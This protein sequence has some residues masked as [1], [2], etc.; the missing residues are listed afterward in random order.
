MAF[1]A[2]FVDNS[3]IGP[4]H[5]TLW[6]I[7]EHRSKIVK[8]WNSAGSFRATVSQ[9]NQKQFSR[10]TLKCLNTTWIKRANAH[11]VKRTQ[12]LI[13]RGTNQGGLLNFM[14]TVL[15]W[16]E[17]SRLCLQGTHDFQT[18]MFYKQVEHVLTEKIED[19]CCVTKF[20]I[21]IITIK[22][23]QKLIAVKCRPK[24]RATKRELKLFPNTLI[25]SYL[26][27]LW[28]L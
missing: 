21:T 9:Y 10:S 12:C 23:F 11:N 4:T 22:L 14:N 20:S 24:K 1:C 17:T 3:G 26:Q 2:A 15:K 25:Y 27:T 8:I 13:K 7:F 6:E 28:R 16:S 18:E 19:K 5:I